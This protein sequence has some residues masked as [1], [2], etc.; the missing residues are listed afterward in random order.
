MT[1][2]KRVSVGDTSADWAKGACVGCVGVSPPK[3]FPPSVP[4]SPPLGFHFC[5]HSIIKKEK[6]SDTSDTPPFSTVKTCVRVQNLHDT[7]AFSTVNICVGVKT[8][9]VTQL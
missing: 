3:Y 9:S 2:L 5:V 6:K 7:R 4:K 8:P 1:G